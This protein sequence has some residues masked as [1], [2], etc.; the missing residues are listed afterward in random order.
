MIVAGL[1]ADEQA[2]VEDHVNGCAACQEALERLTAAP[3]PSGLA[4]VDLNAQTF[5]ARVRAFTPS[6]GP[7]PRPA[8]GPAPLPDVPGY[9]VEAE[10]GRGGMGVVYRARHKRLNR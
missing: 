9:V 2:A 4:D 10:A 8:P 6:A 3:V 7:A 5:V 1:P